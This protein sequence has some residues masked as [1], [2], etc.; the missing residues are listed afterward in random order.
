MMTLV[1]KI[2][3]PLEKACLVPGLILIP[4]NNYINN[5]KNKDNTKMT[6]AVILSFHLN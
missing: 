2:S 4:E 5:N 1:R 3:W 6:R